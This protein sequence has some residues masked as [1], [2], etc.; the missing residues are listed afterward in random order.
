MHL[1]L[2]NIKSAKSNQIVL[3]VRMTIRKIVIH[4]KVFDT[5][6]SVILRGFTYVLRM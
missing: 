1:K 4:L 2:S 5:K 3:I 6:S